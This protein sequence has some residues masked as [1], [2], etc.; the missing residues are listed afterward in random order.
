[1]DIEYFVTNV[2]RVEI[3]LIISQTPQSLIE[4]NLVRLLLNLFKFH[5]WTFSQ[6][7]LGWA[8]NSTAIT[9]QMAYR[10]AIPEAL[11]KPPLKAIDA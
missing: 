10:M 5:S 2:G 4:T 9:W 3:V 11:L 8:A 1:M 7:P 6:L